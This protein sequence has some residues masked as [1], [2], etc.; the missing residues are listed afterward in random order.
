[1]IY[2]ATHIVIKLATYGT[3]GLLF[4]TDACAKFKVTWHKN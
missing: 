2:N 3:V 1:V 4:A